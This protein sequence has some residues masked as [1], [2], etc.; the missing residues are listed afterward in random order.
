MRMNPPTHHDGDDVEEYY[1]EANYGEN[2]M[3]TEKDAD[4][5]QDTALDVS[6]DTTTAID[7]A[8]VTSA[9]TD[10]IA[11]TDI[12][13]DMAVGIPK[14]DEKM[15][16]NKT[17]KKGKIAGLRRALSHSL[18]PTRKMKNKK[19]RDADDDPLVTVES[20]FTNTISASPSYASATS[21]AGGNDARAYAPAILRR[22]SLSSLFRTKS[23]S[24]ISETG[25]PPRSRP[26]TPLPSSSPLRT[27][28]RGTSSSNRLPSEKSCSSNQ[29]G[30]K[31]PGVG[32]V[33][34]NGDKILPGGPDASGFDNEKQQT[35]VATAQDGQT[36]PV[37]NAHVSQYCMAQKSRVFCGIYNEI[38]PDYFFANCN[39]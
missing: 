2:G 23:S 4:V 12:D 28:M 20:N 34:G 24:G 19:D 14:A 22:S 3:P 5:T 7:R 10:V 25:L 29:I 17:K 18:T 27:P 15:E 37:L 32:G 11:A 36:E 8:G 1:N 33:D 39:I 26:S 9:K 38:L 6:V 21:S 30:K 35:T 13:N 16:K 31:L